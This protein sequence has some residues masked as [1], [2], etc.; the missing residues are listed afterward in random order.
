MLQKSY[1]S[2]HSWRKK[3]TTTKN[4]SYGMSREKR[5]REVFQ[6]MPAAGSDWPG[7]FTKQ[8]DH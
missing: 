6:R 5:Q 2:E 3:A 8:Q 4:L 1:S 7:V